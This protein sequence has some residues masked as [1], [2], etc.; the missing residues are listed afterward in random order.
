MAKQRSF[1]KLWHP[2]QWIDEELGDRA[3]FDYHGGTRLEPFAGSHP[4]VM[5]KRI[6]S[7]DWTFEYDPSR[8]RL[9]LKDRVLEWIEAKTGV[10]IGE[11]RNYELI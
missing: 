11:Y 6:K 4:A 7:A 3:I 2:D 1:H 10:R 8:V 9:P 5:E